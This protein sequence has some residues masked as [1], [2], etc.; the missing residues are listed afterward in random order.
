MAPKAMKAM[1]IAMKAIKVATQ[2]TKASKATQAPKTAAASV[3][4]RP[5]VQGITPFYLMC[6]YVGVPVTIR[7]W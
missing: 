7:A 2:P 3:M 6:V 1:K 4:K 5:S